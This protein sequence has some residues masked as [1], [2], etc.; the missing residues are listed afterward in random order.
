MIFQH[1]NLLMQ[2]N[3]LDNVCFPLEIAGM[4]KK[5]A[6]EKA[7]GYLETVG[8]AEKAKAYPAVLSGGQKQRVAIAR[9]LA[10]NPK[11]LLCDEATSAL[12]PQTTKSI[13]GLLKKINEEFGITIV[14]ITHEMA[15]VQEICKHVLVLENGKLQE[16]GTVGEIFRNPKTEA[17]KRLLLHTDER[18]VKR[19]T[20]Q[21]VRL[22]FGQHSAYEPILSNAILQYKAPLNILHAEIQSLNGVNHGQMILQLPEDK[23]LALDIV[24]YFREKKVTVE[25]WTENDG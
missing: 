5:E 25:E 7:M 12:D 16:S 6:R 1:F 17:T 8:L 10:S 13:L 18:I 15:V 4:S 19:V 24:Q 2:R 14:L 11:V 3:V 20:G 9:V 21:I 23:H 22:T